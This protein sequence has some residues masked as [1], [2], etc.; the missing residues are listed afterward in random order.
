MQ[1]T[2]TETPVRVPAGATPEGDGVALGQGPVRID[3]YIDFMCPFCRQFEERSGAF[4]DQLLDS[5]A[6]TLVYHPLGFLD[7]LSTTRYSSRASAASACAS[8]F[9]VFKPYKDALF[10]NQPPEGGPGLSAEELVEL[11]RVVGLRDQRFERCVLEETHLPWTDFVSQVAAERGISGTP[12][13][14]VGGV[15]V[16]ANGPAIAA[17]V[18]E[19]TG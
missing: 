1:R 15:P 16:P 14:F 2:I 13:V 5:G 18:A 17:T 6:V 10:A 7:R 9:D 3:A 4:L 11:G 19:L 8:D 12:S